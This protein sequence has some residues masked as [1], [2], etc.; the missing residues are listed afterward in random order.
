MRMYFN[1]AHQF[2]VIIFDRISHSYFSVNKWIMSLLTTLGHSM[3]TLTIVMFFVNVNIVPV[4]AVSV[5][6]WHI[7]LHHS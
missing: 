3:C 5:Q 1:L 7:G 4:Y 2:S 6:L